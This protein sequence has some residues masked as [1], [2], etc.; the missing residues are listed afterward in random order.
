MLTSLRE[1]LAR[2]G[3]EFEV[4]LREQGERVR[5]A[6]DKK[7]RF[8]LEK[9]VAARGR[10]RGME[11]V[12]LAGAAGG[13]E[14]AHVSPTKTGMVQRR[15]DNLPRPG[16]G[17]AMGKGEGMGGGGGGGG[18]VV[19]VDF[20]SMPGAGG[21]GFDG[22][23]GG[24]FMTPLEMQQLDSASEQTQLLIPQGDSYLQTRAEAV[25]QIESHISE[26]GAVF[27]KLAGLVQ[28]HGELVQRV[29]D[30]VDDAHENVES[31]MGQLVKVLEGLKSGKMLGLKITGILVLFIIF[32]ITFLA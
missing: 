9:G 16:A 3:E 14:D 8:G 10:I 6:S 23:G 1:T 20:S 31:G 2:Q 13:G 4:V 28:H 19:G 11:K 5:V 25:E 32:F 30:N 27:Q 18:G 15:K 17:S 26:L 21:E 24:S 12:R 29:E 22:G 7:R